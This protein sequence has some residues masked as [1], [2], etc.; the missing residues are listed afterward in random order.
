MKKKDNQSFPSVTIIIPMRNSATTVLETLK[1]IVQQ[2]YP[3]EKIIVVDNVS[4]DNSRDLVLNFA[5]KSK[6][7]IKLIRQEKDKGVSSSNNLGAKAAKSEL[8]VFMMSDSVLPAKNELKKLVSPLVND[9]RVVAT[10]PTTVLPRKVWNEYNFWQ[11][12]YMV[13]D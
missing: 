13:S 1:T 9:S 6:I 2:T 3:I 4:K 7:P 10:Y 5:K 8:I 12:L 11:K